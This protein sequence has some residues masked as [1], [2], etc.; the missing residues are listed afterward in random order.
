MDSEKYIVYKRTS[1]S[2]H[3]YVG[4]TKVGLMERWIQTQK[5]LKNSNT[6]LANAIRKY[7]AD[8]WS[9]EVLF[10]T[11]NKQEALDAEEV[12][13]SL[14]G[15]YNVAKGGSGGNTGKNNDPEKIKK[16]ATSLSNHYQNLPQEEKDRR[17]AAS[18]SSRE[19]NGTLGNCNPKFD[20]EHGNWTG[21]WVVKG[22]K[23][24]TLK[25]ASEGSGIPSGSIPGLCS[26]HVDKVFKEDSKYVPAGKSPR[27]CG[28]YKTRK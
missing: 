17:V 24:S 19:A 15:H 28:F 20:T 13:I 22:I 2:N 5:D 12:Y 11:D 3:I 14:L 10:E 4:Y 1:P 25:K 23:Y 6:P 27:E 26:T 21:Y 16:Q 9:H 18:I 8:S 7:G